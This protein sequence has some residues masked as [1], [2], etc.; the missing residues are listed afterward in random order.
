MAK[1]RRKD[2][3]KRSGSKGKRARVAE[4]KDEGNDKPMT[5]DEKM[6]LSLAINKLSGKK[7]YL[8]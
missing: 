6:R 4:D 8:P 2:K 5:F 7:V 3:C 1:P